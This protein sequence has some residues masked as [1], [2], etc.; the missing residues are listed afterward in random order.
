MGMSGMSEA[1][2]AELKEHLERTLWAVREIARVLSE[3]PPELREYV[4]TFAR[5]AVD[6]QALWQHESKGSVET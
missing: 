4:M 6:K 5:S 2:V 1:A 3:V